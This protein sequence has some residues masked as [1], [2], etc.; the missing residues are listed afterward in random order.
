MRAIQQSNDAA[1]CP[2]DNVTRQQMAAFIVRAVTGDDTDYLQPHSL[3]HRCADDESVLLPTFKR[4]R[5]WALP[6]AAELAIA[7]ARQTGF[8]RW[9]MAIF[10]VRARLALYGAT[11]TTATIPYFGDVPTNVEGNGIAFPFIQRSYE[12]HIT[13]MAAEAI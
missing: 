6:L 1:Y 8:P 2:N 13:Q 5:S 4:W 12:E 3:F 10:I 9:E 7:P 11:F